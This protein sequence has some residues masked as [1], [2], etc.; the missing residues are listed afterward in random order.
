MVV[1]TGQFETSPSFLPNEKSIAYAVFYQSHHFWCA[2]TVHFKNHRIG[3]EFL[4]FDHDFL[5]ALG[6]GVKLVIFNPKF[7]GFVALAQLGVVLRAVEFKFDIVN[8]SGLVIA[9]GPMRDLPT[10]LD[11]GLVAQVGSTVCEAKNQK[12]KQGKVFHLRKFW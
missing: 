2:A 8:G 12:S 10:A 7:S 1:T 9:S 6:M 5:L 3:G 11:F 4:D